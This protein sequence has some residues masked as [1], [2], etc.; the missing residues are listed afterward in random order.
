MIANKD[1]KR[2]NVTDKLKK[3]YPEIENDIEDMRRVL[4][5]IG[6]EKKNLRGGAENLLANPN[7]SDEAKEKILNF[8]EYKPETFKELGL[9]ADAIIDFYIGENGLKDGMD[10]LYADLKG[11]DFANSTEEVVLQQSLIGMYN[12]LAASKV[13]ANTKKQALE[14]T[15]DI[16]E[17]YSKQGTK[18]G[19]AINAYRLLGALTAEGRVVWSQRQVKKYVKPAYEGLK[20]EINNLKAELKDAYK[21]VDYFFEQTLGREE[22]EGQYKELIAQYQAEIDALN[23]RKSREPKAS[24]P[25]YKG[26]KA[27]REFKESDLANFAKDILEGGLFQD[28][29]SMTAPQKLAYGIMEKKPINIVEFAKAFSKYLGKK[30][31]PKEVQELYK[32]TRDLLIGKDLAFSEGLSSN[33]QL[34]ADLAGLEEANKARIEE[35]ERKKA[36]AE[37]KRAAKVESDKIDRLQKELQDLQN[38]ILTDKTG[39]QRKAE[40]KDVVDFRQ[41][42]ADLKKKLAE[43]K[44][45]QAAAEV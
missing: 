6:V 31:D 4:Q 37:I 41:K 11:G 39:N 18:M 13:D 30:I 23:S 45:K 15:V 29:E 17:S 42:I 24:K 21:Q 3:L 32:Q 19:Q 25:A 22:T 8:S 35:L 27:K 44:A 16:A 34:S 14:R 38:G 1:A 7:I 26:V 5:E 12:K 9:K 20:T 10:K 2:Y 43:D 36:E 28:M 40:S 33:Q